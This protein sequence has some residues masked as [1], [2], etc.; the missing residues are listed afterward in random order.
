MFLC[1]KNLVPA[2]FLLGL[3]IGLL[4]SALCPGTLLLILGASAL[5]LAVCLLRN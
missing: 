1:R 5:I 3:G 4:L 2:S